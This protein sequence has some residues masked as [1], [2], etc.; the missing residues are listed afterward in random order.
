LLLCATG[1][2]AGGTLR[3]ALLPVLRWCVAGFLV[4]TTRVPERCGMRTW[5]VVGAWLSPKRASLLREHTDQIL[6]ESLGL[7]EAEIGRLSDQ[8]VVAGAT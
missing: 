1:G 7:S 8:G 5:L 6:G 4:V 3:P 2:C